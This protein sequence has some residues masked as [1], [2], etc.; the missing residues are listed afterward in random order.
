LRWVPLFTE[1]SSNRRGTE[2]VELE[3]ARN[4][5]W[6]KLRR[7][8]EGV[9]VTESVAGSRSPLGANELVVSAGHG[10]AGNDDAVL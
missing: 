8:R 2:L 7:E 6:A 5:D 10:D 9:W 3:R 1:L 4:G